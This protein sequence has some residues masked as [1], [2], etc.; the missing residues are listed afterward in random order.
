M[1]IDEICAIDCS[2]F[3]SCKVFSYDPRCSYEMASEKN[4]NT[5]FEV[6]ES[7]PTPARETILRGFTKTKKLLGKYCGYEIYSLAPDKVPLPDLYPVLAANF[8]ENISCDFTNRTKTIYS[9]LYF[10][11]K[12][13]DEKILLVARNKDFLFSCFS[14]RKCLNRFLASYGF[15]KNLFY[16]SRSQ[17]EELR[18]FI[19]KKIYL[20]SYYF[21]SSRKQSTTT[22]FCEKEICWRLEVDFRK[23]RLVDFHL[24]T[25]ASSF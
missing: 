17:L 14:D 4:S 23:E 8:S 20:D 24:I 12:I 13:T 22:V 6:I 9:Y 5:N 19:S 18:F 2:I 7:C 16:G 25:G 15:F 21:D 1:R 11:E 3:F 10:E